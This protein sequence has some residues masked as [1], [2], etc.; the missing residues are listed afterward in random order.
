[1]LGF[2]AVSGALL[3]WLRRKK[4]GHRR[5][6]R[7][8]HSVAS[9]VITCLA[10]AATILGLAL[11]FVGLQP[12]NGGRAALT[13]GRTD[14]DQRIGW[15]IGGLVAL[16]AGV[17][18]YRLALRFSMPRPGPA[19]LQ[20]PRPAILYLRSFADDSLR[21]RVAPFARASLLER[22][23]ARRKQ[24]FEEVMAEELQRHGPVVAVS[25]PGRWLAP[26]G[27]ARQSLS[28]AE[29]QTSVRQRMSECGLVVVVVG[30]SRGL[31]WE[32]E[33]LFETGAWRKALFLFPPVKDLCARWTQ[34]AD[35]LP[36]KVSRSIAL[37]PR[38]L[39]LAMTF[40][41][42][43]EPR[44]FCGENLSAWSYKGAV[45]CALRR[46]SWDSRQREGPV[47]SKLPIDDRSAQLAADSATPQKGG[48]SANP[49][50]DDPSHGSGWPHQE[51]STP[52]NRE[53]PRP[54]GADHIKTP[55]RGQKR[56]DH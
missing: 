8:R 44:Y 55:E 23:S 4:L 45:A 10:V 46:M 41:A 28:D 29:W 22:L 26:I 31:L 30:R 27:F 18:I 20:D 53:L 42:A 19:V 51:P 33:A 1:V 54:S 14:G 43:G 37:R 12:A 21:I 49:G 47:G 17:A 11:F 6:I 48:V 16:S 50:S 5:A 38:V 32:V 52:C 36:I 39:L 13:T 15:V 25:E 35:A 3:Y 56:L 40:D 2:A 34:L 7:R 9:M 24:G